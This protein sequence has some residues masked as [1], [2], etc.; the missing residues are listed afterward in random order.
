MEAGGMYSVNHPPYRGMSIPGVFPCQVYFHV[1]HHYNGKHHVTCGHTRQKHHVIT[2]VEN[3]TNEYYTSS[4]C[5]I[6]IVHFML[7]LFLLFL[8]LLLSTSTLSSSSNINQKNTTPFFVCVLCVNHTT[9]T[10]VFVTIQHQDS[11]ATSRQW[12]HINTVTHQHH[13]ATGH[14]LACCCVRSVLL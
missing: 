14:M 9:S 10:H 1:K 11:G 5:Y 2:L 12:C 8:F 7:S 3:T 6:C 4:G 13:G